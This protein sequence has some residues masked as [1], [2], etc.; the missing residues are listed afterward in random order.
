MSNVL[1][2]NPS[3]DPF[4]EIGYRGYA[5]R[6]TAHRQYQDLFLPSVEV[7]CRLQE[8]EGAYFECTTLYEFANADR[9]LEWTLMKGRSMV[10]SFLQQRNVRSEYANKHIVH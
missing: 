3:F 7:R 9:A 2:S 10:D 8:N 5:I 6:G 1:Q 4:I